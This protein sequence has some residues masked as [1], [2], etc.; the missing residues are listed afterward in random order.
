MYVSSRPNYE[1]WKFCSSRI[2]ET[3]VF[4]TGECWRL[5]IFPFIEK[6][7]LGAGIIC[8]RPHGGFHA[9]L[10]SQEVLRDSSWWVSLLPFSMLASGRRLEL[11]LPH[12]SRMPVFQERGLVAWRSAYV[13]SLNVMLSWKP[14][15]DHQPLDFKVIEELFQYWN[16]G[17]NCTWIMWIFLRVSQIWDKGHIHYI[18]AFCESIWHIFPVR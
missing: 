13:V 8:E 1:Q 10:F 11:L 5:G 7:S 15:L 6:F 2:E 14:R 18:H 12:W 16:L 3:A 9:Q 17:V 4:L